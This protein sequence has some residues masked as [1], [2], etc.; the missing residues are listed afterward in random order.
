[1]WITL[2]ITVENV[3]YFLEHSLLDA[4]SALLTDEKCP[5]AAQK[6]PQNMI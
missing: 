2:L 6:N 3:D 1:L 4:K 5:K